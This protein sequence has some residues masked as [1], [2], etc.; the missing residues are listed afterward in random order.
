MYPQ[1]RPQRITSGKVESY[2]TGLHL[3][4]QYLEAFHLKQFKQNCQVEPINVQ[5]FAKIKLLLLSVVKR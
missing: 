4:I 1:K 2:E 5:Y 3:P